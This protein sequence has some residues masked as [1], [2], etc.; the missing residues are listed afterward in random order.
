MDFKT[1][2]VKGLAAIFLLLHHMVFLVIY[3]YK[4]MRKIAAKPDTYP[5]FL[6]HL[7][8]FGYFC[9]ADQLRNYQFAPLT[10]FILFEM[11]FS[12][13]TAFFIVMGRI[14]KIKTAFSTV[15]V[16][17]SYTLLPTLLW[18]IVTS[19]LYS[20]LPP[21]RTL[22]TLGIVFSLVYITFSLCLLFWKLLLWFLAIRYA[23]QLSFYRVM[24]A[25]LL[26]ITLSIPFFMLLNSFRLFRVPFI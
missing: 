25:I 6:L 17:L 15:F 4:T 18:F 8:I 3:P 12:L 19:I 20:I 21:P 9:W 10:V 16:T 1:W 2:G 5:I 24:Y 14:F 13:S 26:H 23:T 11:I 22:S 7:A